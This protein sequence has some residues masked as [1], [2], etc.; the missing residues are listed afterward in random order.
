MLFSEKLYLFIFWCTI[1]VLI[2][3]SCV[4]STI[5]FALCWNHTVQKL[6]LS[7]ENSIDIYSAISAAF[8][9]SVLIRC[10]VAQN[11]SLSFTVPRNTKSTRSS[12]PRYSFVKSNPTRNST[13]STTILGGLP[14][15]HAQPARGRRRRGH[16]RHVCRRRQRQ[17]RS[18]QLQRVPEDD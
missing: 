8:C 5:L 4:S 6:A 13:E 9:I 11:L 10:S 16:R 1:N 17:R 15:H 2:A 3:I 7:W 12:F 18:D 14:L